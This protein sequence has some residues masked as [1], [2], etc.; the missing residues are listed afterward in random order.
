MSDPDLIL[1]QN[2]LFTDM[3]TSM[4]P[5]LKPLKTNCSVQM[6]KDQPL[7]NITLEEG[8]YLVYFVLDL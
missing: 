2:L 6:Y 3:K 4:K 7:P 8:R 1:V 5:K